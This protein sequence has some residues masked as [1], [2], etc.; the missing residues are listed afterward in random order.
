MN[1]GKASQSYTERAIEPEQ[2]LVLTF[3]THIIFLS[4]FR[5]IINNKYQHRF[6]QIRESSEIAS[7]VSAGAT[8]ITV[9]GM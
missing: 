4:I 1:Q 8:Y 3:V 7:G 9:L 5:S 6:I 2:N